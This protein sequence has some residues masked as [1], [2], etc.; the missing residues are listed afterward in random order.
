MFRLANGASGQLTASQVCSGA[1]N[2]LRIEIYGDAGSIQ[3]A[4]E[5]P[6]TMTVSRR[7]EPQQVLQPGSN[8]G[9]LSAAAIAVCRT[10]GGHP[11]G[12]I[13]AFANLYAGFARAVREYPSHSG[14]GCAS[15][16]D[17]VATMR[18]IRAA[19]HSSQ[20]NSAWTNL[21]GIENKNT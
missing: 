7:G 15:V 9:Y 2:S 3:W 17:G 6:N 20:K 18:F 5:A 16:A 14:T 21:A 13:E 4:Q 10:P 1:V 8:V 19:L 11:E 12:Y